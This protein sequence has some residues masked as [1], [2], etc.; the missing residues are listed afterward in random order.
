MN[1]P[2]VVRVLLPLTIAWF[3]LGGRGVAQISLELHESVSYRYEEATR[4]INCKSTGA[5]GDGVH[6]LVALW[7]KAVSS[8]AAPTRSAASILTS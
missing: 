1:G 5:G 6:T 7:V 2:I 3:V 4:C 8:R